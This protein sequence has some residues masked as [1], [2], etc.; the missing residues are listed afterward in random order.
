VPPIS[1]WQKAGIVTRVAGRQL[2]QSRLLRAGFSAVR[3]TADHFGRVVHLLWLQIT[4]VFFLV[5]AM[6][7]G[8]AAWREYVRWQAGKIGPGKMALAL[9]FALVFAWFGVSSFYRAMKKSNRNR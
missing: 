9:C 6:G 1:T 7:G 4:G 3:I 5:F 2:G 8:A